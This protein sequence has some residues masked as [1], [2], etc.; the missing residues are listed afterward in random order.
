MI[1]QRHRISRLIKHSRSAFPATFA[2]LQTATARTG[3]LASVLQ[4]GFRRILGECF[5]LPNRMSMVKGPRLAFKKCACE[6]L[7]GV[8]RGQIRIGDREALQSFRLWEWFIVLGGWEYL[9][10]TARLEL[11]LP[12]FIYHADHEFQANIRATPFPGVALAHEHVVRAGRLDI[13]ACFSPIFTQRMM[14][15]GIIWIELGGFFKRGS[16]KLASI[17]AHVS[18]PQS[19]PEKSVLRVGL[20]FLLQILDCII[21]GPG[22]RAIVKCWQAK[23]DIAISS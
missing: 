7:P 15:L 21:T 12:Q 6:F 14:R 18:I 4:F 9:D 2:V 16:R 10:R 1:K 20:D 17:S 13:V 11:H 3:A 8:G 19:A 23:N 5:F 22:N